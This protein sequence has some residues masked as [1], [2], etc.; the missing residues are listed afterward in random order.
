MPMVL[1]IKTLSEN[2]Y[3]NDVLLA[4]THSHIR[5]GVTVITAKVTSEQSE[6]Q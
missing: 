6:V 2:A 1:S 3:Q 5:L 4:K